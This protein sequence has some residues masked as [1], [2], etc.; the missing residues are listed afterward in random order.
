MFFMSIH[1]ARKCMYKQ[2]MS[3]LLLHWEKGQ[4]AVVA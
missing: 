2:I 4:D 1:T 3:E